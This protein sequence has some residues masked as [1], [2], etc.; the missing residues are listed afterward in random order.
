MQTLM[1]Q[2]DQKW[3]AAR[4]STD[5][6][7][8]NKS[9]NQNEGRKVCRRHNNQPLNVV[10]SPQVQEGTVGLNQHFSLLRASLSYWQGQGRRRQID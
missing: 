10:A 4:D 9:C 1:T 2:T 6:R 5:G 3:E 7:T 8:S